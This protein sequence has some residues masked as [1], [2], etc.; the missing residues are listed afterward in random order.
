MSSYTH[1]VFYRVDHLDFDDLKDLIRDAYSK[2][3]NWRADEIKLGSWQ[4]QS[5]DATF[6]EQLAKMDEG[7]LF[8]FIYRKG[9][10][11]DEWNKWRIEI[12]F[13]ELIHFLWVEVEVEHLDY[14]IEYYKLKPMG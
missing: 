8:R 2:S 4:R 9:F 5:I 11:E 14:F 1:D 13:N 10:P 6:E 12:V 3:Y 7:S